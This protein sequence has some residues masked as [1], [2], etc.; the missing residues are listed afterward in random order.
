[1]VKPPAPT[2]LAQNLPLPPK[3]PLHPPPP[4]PTHQPHRVAKPVPL[5]RSALNTLEKLRAL[6][7]HQKPPKAPANPAQ[8]GAP[9]A[10]GNPLSADTA[11]L[12]VAER[13]AI[14]DHVRPCWTKDAGALDVNKLQVELLV[15][16]D[17]AGVARI[18]HVAPADRARVDADPVLRAFADRAVNAVLNVKCATLPLPPSMLGK[19]HRFL[20]LFRP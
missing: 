17:A 3:P 19:V 14:G 2:K 5:S 16:T 9:N 13:G 4:S 1:M 11:A 18:V 10:G 7:R 15:T 12:S 6:Q 20:F 8:G